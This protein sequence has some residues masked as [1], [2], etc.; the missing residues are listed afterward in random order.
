M[1][2][3]ESREAAPCSPRLWEEMGGGEQPWK[4]S[5][6][7]SRKTITAT[8]SHVEREKPHWF[9]ILYSKSARAW[10]KPEPSLPSLGGRIQVPQA[11]PGLSRLCPEAVPAAGN[12]LSWAPGGG[13]TS[14]LQF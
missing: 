14:T 5:P 8:E 13:P 1:W 4:Q 2:G 11:C 3:V 9:R 7:Q 10:G 6:E 12:I